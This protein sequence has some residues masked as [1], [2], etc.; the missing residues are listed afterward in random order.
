MNLINW[1]TEGLDLWISELTCL[2]TVCLS[3]FPALLKKAISATQFR[4]WQIKTPSS[5]LHRYKALSKPCS[6]SSSNLSKI[7]VKSLIWLWNSPM[8]FTKSFKRIAYPQKLLLPNLVKKGISTL[9]WWKKIY[10]FQAHFLT[11]F[12]KLKFDERFGEGLDMPQF[13]QIE[14]LQ[15]NQN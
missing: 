3:M 5:N 8:V 12:I 15:R 4:A 11:L 6:L 2:L 10:L 9:I 13:N 14:K 1:N 7:L